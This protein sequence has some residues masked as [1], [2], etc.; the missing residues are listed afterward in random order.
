MEKLV[1]LDIDGDLHQGA[2][3][4]LEIREDGKRAVTQTRAKGKLPPA[5]ELIE[6]CDRWQSLY[7]NLSFLFRLEERGGQIAQ[8]STKD[9]LDSCR[10]SAETLA[11]SLTTWLKAESFRPIREKLLEKLSPSDTVRLI[12]QIEDNQLRRLPWHLW[13]FFERYPKAEVALGATAYERVENLGQFREKPRILAILGNGN[14][15]DIEADRRL[16]SS[17]L[18]DAEIVFL[19]EPQRQQLYQQLWDSAGWD[20][21]FFAGHSSSQATGETGE[22]E[23]NSSD[24]LTITELTYALKKA[25]ARGLQLAIFNSCD[26]LGL[27]RSL[28]SLHIPQIIVMRE[29]VPD[30]V[31]QEFLKYFLTAFASGESFYTAV[32]EAREQL[33]AL[34]DRCPC[35]SWLPVICQNPTSNFRFW[36][37]DFGLGSED[38]RHEVLEPN[39]PA[40]NPK[41]TTIAARRVVQNPKC[42]Y[43][44]LSAFQEADAQFFFG[45]EAYTEKLL[46]AVY[47]RSLV[48]T[49]GPSG[50]GKSSVVF[51]GLI[52]RLRLTQD[53]LIVSFRPGNR[54]FLKLAEQLILLLEPDLSET[55]RLVE[56]NKLATAVQQRDLALAD[57]VERILHKT[58]IARACFQTSPPDSDPPQPPLRRGEN[59]VKVPLFKGDLGGSASLKT[60]PTRLLLVADQFE[61]LY[62]LCPGVET[63]QRFLDELLATVNQAPNFTLILTLRADF[64][65]Y[66]LSYHP[67]A[68]ALQRFPPEFLAPMSSEELQAAIEKPAAQLG[69][70]IEEG[71]RSRIL[72]AVS[73]EPG[74]LPLLQFALTLLW[75]QQCNGILTHA[76]YD[77]IGGVEQALASYAEKVYTA[78][79][80]AEQQQA[81]QIFLQLVHPGEGTADTRRIATCTEVGQD[82]WNLVTRLADARL[83]VT[84]QDEATSVE[85]VEIVHEALIREWQRLRQWLEENRSFRTWQERLR[86]TMRQ[87][88]T[89]N[90]DEGILWR[91][92]PLLE[93]QHWYAERS[94]DLSLKEQNFIQASLALQAREL[95]IRD[96]RR[97]QV[98]GGLTTALLGTVLLVA[99]A[100]WQWQ[101]AE[102]NAVDAQLNDLS[103]SSAELLASNKE[104]E[105]LLESLKAGRQLQRASKVNPDTRI[106]VLTVLQQAVYGVREYNRLVHRRTVI[107]VSFS[108][109]GK[110]I[111]SASDDGTVKLWRKDGTLLKTL[112]G[113]TANV[114][115]VSFS[116]DGQMLASASYDNTVRLW[117]Q[118]GKAIAILIGHSNKVNSVTFSPDG[119]ILASASADKTVKLWRTSGTPIA[120]LKGHRS[121]VTS[122]SFSPD[123]QTLATAGTDKTIRLWSRDGK[124][125]STLNG[126]KASINSVSFSPNGKMLASASGDKTVKLWQRDGKL[127]KT[128]TEHNDKVWSVSFSPDGLTFASA[129]ADKTVKLWQ[130]DGRAIATLKGHTASIYTVSFSPDGQSIAS[131]SADATVKLWHPNLQKLPTLQNHNSDV[132]GVSFS[133]DGQALV[134]ASGDKTIKLWHPNGSAIA[135]LKGHAA[136]IYSINFSP[137]GLSFASAGADKTVKLWHRDGTLLKTFNGHSGDVFG[138]N[139]SPDG[140]TLAS[141]S[142]DKTV[143]LWHRD[144]RAI[145]TLIG[146]K[147][148]VTSVSFSPDGQMLASASADETIKLWRLDGSLI[149]T[150]EEHSADVLSV[151][152]SP[153]G[154]VLA[155]ASADGSVK[156]WSLGGQLLKTLTGHTNRVNSISFS[157]N[158]EIIASASADGTVKLWNVSGKLLKT[159]KGHSSSVLSVSFSPDG[160]T[161]ASA[162]SDRTIVL[163]NFDLDALLVLDC[164]W[165]RDYLR[166]RSILA[167]DRHLCDK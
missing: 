80:S 142:A 156:I 113:H 89:S 162:S 127:I 167:S 146:H 136:A 87:W 22:I 106:R 161:I 59:S 155:S 126:H 54:P 66:A 56:I 33:Q 24:R 110:T 69:V 115:S 128:L 135:N 38:E 159:L 147:R 51:A 124:L 7:R 19:V 98:I 137:D 6:Q 97:Q 92:A 145:A 29:P 21:L 44:G 35:A 11:D 8:G 72:D 164:A 163:W 114:R 86:T 34:E 134:S 74:Q 65:E 79:K 158:G 139:F 18:C 39:T 10:Q 45:R 166:S 122:V 102:S 101:R 82:N 71:L 2:I 150:L 78:L 85:T 119:E 55:D 143:K 46:Q 58:A 70:Q 153:Q 141:A 25:I 94:A 42:P 130:M 157:P 138:V 109:D 30:L 125:L 36:I 107:G 61:E 68:S 63:R 50:S 3:A 133:P 81:K 140:Q 76:A 95:R 116:P 149:T 118:D 154:S 64:C 62:T 41:S 131:A 99:I 105:A 67:F 60:D 20:I 53:W 57:V 132:W 40:D 120:T 9:I 77:A 12:L 117:R 37:L 93:A 151:S 27:A 32:R 16:L 104:L 28:E 90:Q 15:I 121:W 43:Q 148:G 13:D 144:G 73:C 83:V 165:M 96:R 111:A 48:T 5:P 52:P 17:L 4:T 100:T 84:R 112:G 160:Q 31:A 88:E 23:I 26:G 129:S 103:A 123:G 108:P 1:I 75:E 47:E 49:I 152:F 91:G 14:G